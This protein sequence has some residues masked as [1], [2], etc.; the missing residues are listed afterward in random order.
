[1]GIHS[2]LINEVNKKKPNDQHNEIKHNQSPMNFRSFSLETQMG[3]TSFKWGSVFSL[4]KSLV[5]LC[6][7]G[8]LCLFLSWPK[9][10]IANESEG[11]NREIGG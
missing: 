3:K 9:I 11:R 4:W 1:M 8:L 5:T 10:P 2:H 6:V 7:H